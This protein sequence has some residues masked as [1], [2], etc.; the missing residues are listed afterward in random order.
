LIECDDVGTDGT[1]DQPQLFPPQPKE[2]LLRSLRANL[3]LRHFSPRPGEAYTA[4]VTALLSHLA[5]ELPGGL[6]NQYPGA[7]RTWPWQWVHP[8]RR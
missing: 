7:G 3:R 6:G 8:A 2:K 4:E 5:V 1:E